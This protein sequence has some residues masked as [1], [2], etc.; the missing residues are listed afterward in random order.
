[1]PHAGVR[2]RSNEPGSIFLETLQA[3]GPLS[4]GRVGLVVIARYGD[5]PPSPPCPQPKFLAA[6]PLAI[7][8]QVFSGAESCKALF[9]VGRI[10][11]FRLVKFA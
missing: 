9:H 2:P 4:V 1:M 6:A 10:S 5:T 3:A 7:F 11:V 8:K